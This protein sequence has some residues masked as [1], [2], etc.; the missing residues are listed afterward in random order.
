VIWDD[1]RSVEVTSLEWEV[2]MP[3]GSD[4]LAVQFEI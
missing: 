4:P 3:M 2:V 1:G